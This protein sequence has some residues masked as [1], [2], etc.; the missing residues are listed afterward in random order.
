[1]SNV[2]NAGYIGVGSFINRMHL[3]HAYQNP[4]VCVHT[5]CDLNED[6]LRQRAEAY[7]PLKTT[8][9]YRELLA[10][11][12]V[13][14]V[15]IGTR[16]MLHKKFIVEAANSGKN[17]L[18]EKPMTRTWEETEE[19]VRAVREN[20]VR[21]V[22][23]FNRRCSSPMLETKRLFDEVRNGPVN[24]LYRMAT[25]VMD[26]PD[27][28]AF[29]LSQGGGHLIHEGVH[30]FD[31][32]T[33][34]VES[35]PIRIYCQG[36][37][38]GDDNV[39]ITYADG[40]VAS[41][42]LS[43]NGGQCY[44]KE[45]MEIF[46]GRSTIVMDQFFEVRADLYP[47]RF[48]RKLFPA[49]WDEVAD[50]PGITGRDG[51]IDLHYKKS[52]VLRAKGLYWEQRLQPDKGHYNMLDRYADVLLGGGGRAPSDEIDGARSTCMALKAYESIRRNEA[53]E[54]SGDDYFLPLRR[55]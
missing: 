50:V 3:P 17:I 18:V 27:F 44:P 15:I 31:L 49:H 24:I 35:E 29:D 11:P 41:Y 19:A 4:K 53:I 20:D 40:T 52:A 34:L 28:Y 25:D 55:S 22:V 10:D 54:I 47:D 7:R 48:E 1:M 26:A 23:G 6:L 32:I 5:L 8:M 33:W 38:H 14:L 43:R 2:V 12:E 30:I 51:G 37:V 13:D 45:A 46:A 16:V 42:L 21:L 39:T 36:S 9:D